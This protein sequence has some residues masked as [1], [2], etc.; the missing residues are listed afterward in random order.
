MDVFEIIGTLFAYLTET[1]DPTIP[2]DE[3]NG[4][5]SDQVGL[6]TIT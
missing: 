6:C 5:S 1:D 2:K 3:D 4:S